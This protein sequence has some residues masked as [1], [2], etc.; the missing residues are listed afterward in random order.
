VSVAPPAAVSVARRAPV[1]LSAPAHDCN[2]D[3]AQAHDL[4]NEGDQHVKIDVLGAIE[5]YTEASELLPQDHRILWKLAVA[6]EKTEDW[7]RMA[8]VTQ[9]AAD[10]APQFANYWY[11]LGLA[12]INLAEAGDASAYE[13]AKAPLARCIEKDPQIAECDYLLG[14]AYQFTDDP[15]AALA[16]YSRAIQVD[17]TRGFFYPSLADLYLNLKLPDQA[18]TV[19]KEG[20][21]V[22][23]PSVQNNPKLYNM[24]VLS[25]KV[26]QM[27]ADG[28][29]QLRAIEQAGLY[30][31]DRHPEYAFSL[32]STYTALGSPK[33]QQA[34]EQLSKFM[35]DVCR[36]GQAPKFREEC[37]ESAALLARL[38][39]P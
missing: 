15:Q 35:R 8:E 33:R 13:R 31:G 32:G 27:R 4:A 34:I 14:E 3:R 11:K 10:L 36:S 12:T 25:A 30:V 2:A 38:G 9:R 37:E 6:Y 20:I 17:P 16:A 18:E 7:E 21:R 19:L 28:A 26:A 1:A 29:G 5:R 39:S 22:I 23:A 24:W